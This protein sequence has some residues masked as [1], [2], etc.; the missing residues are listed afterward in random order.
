MTV[1]C[2]V[3]AS[4]ALF[5]FPTHKTVPIVARSLGCEFTDCVTRVDRVFVSL[6]IFYQ[7][8]FFVCLSPSLPS[9]FR[10]P[11]AIASHDG[12]LSLSVSLF[13]SS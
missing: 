8:L 5:P 2:T 10:D 11:P 4:E 9:S 3:T 7:W 12:F 6:S 13:F 1:A